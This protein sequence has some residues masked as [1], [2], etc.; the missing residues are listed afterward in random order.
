MKKAQQ[1]QGGSN[2]KRWIWIVVLLSNYLLPTKTIK[3]KNIDFFES[4]IHLVLSSSCS[5]H[6]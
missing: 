4:I 2:T 1:N 6:T 3:M 5:Y